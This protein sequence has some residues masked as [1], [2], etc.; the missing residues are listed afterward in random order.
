VTTAPKSEAVTQEQ[1]RS[2]FETWLAE[3]SVPTWRFESTHPHWPEQYGS[4][5][6]EWQ[7]RAWQAAH[8]AGRAAAGKDAEDARRYRWLRKRI[9]VRPTNMVSGAVR[10]CLNVRI[11][12][13]PIDA[14]LPESRP[15]DA[16]E[17]RAAKLDAAIDR[18]MAE[19]ET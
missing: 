10:D 11:G 14:D 7:W 17:K 5:A 12:C 16:R 15:E 13:A 19:K 18:A 4:H 6:T 1:M 3:Q 2:A 9:E 8:A